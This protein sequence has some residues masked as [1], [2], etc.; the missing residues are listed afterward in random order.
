MG[1]QDGHRRVARRPRAGS[2]RPTRPAAGPRHGDQAA[3]QRRA[4]C[5]G[6]RRPRRRC[7]R[8]APVSSRAQDSC[9]SVRIVVAPSRCLQNDAKSWRPTSSAEAAFMASRSSGRGQASTCARVSG[10]SAAGAVGDPVGVAAP[11]RAEAGVEARAAPRPPGVPARR[12]ARMPLS[13]RTSRV[14]ASGGSS[15]STCTT[16]PRACTPASVRPA[17]TTATDSA[18]AAWS[19]APP[20]ARPARCAAPAGWPSRGS[21]CRRRRGRAG[22]ARGQLYCAAC[23]GCVVCPAPRHRPHL[24]G[25]RRRDARGLR[26]LPRGVRRPRRP[27][28]PR[29]ARDHP[30][31]RRRRRHG[32][33]V[34]E[35]V[36]CCP[37]PRSCTAST[38]SA[39]RCRP[40]AG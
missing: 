10:S 6:R 36:A 17:Q 15:R 1:V 35:R 5:C 33:D 37:T 2:R 18:P 26:P 27:L 32:R 23:L 22:C 24:R 39:R 16:W 40:R 34:R 21:R 14:R 25:A 38:S 11:Q 30:R 29:G 19:R 12:R 31:H 20:A 8:R 7:R 28:L 13:R 9:S 4:P 3:D